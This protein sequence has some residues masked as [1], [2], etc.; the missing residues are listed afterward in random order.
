MSFETACRR[1]TPNEIR[2]ELT[3][4]LAS[5]EFLAS[6]HLTQFLRYVV[7]E[8]LAGR[9][10]LIKERS[11][12]L[13]ALDRDN[14]FDPREDCIVRV[15]AGKL[16]RAL[17]RYYA[18]EGAESSVR[19]SV[20]KGA[21]RPVFC[22]PA[23]RG[24]VRRRTG[25]GPAGLQVAS[26]SADRQ[27]I[28]RPV[29]AVVPLVPFT[30]GE[31]ER[32]LADSLAQDVAVHLSKVGWI[33]VIDYLATRSDAA[34]G[35]GPLEVASRLHA[36]YALTGTVRR[37]ESAARVTSQLLSVPDGSTVW[38]DQFDLTF[39]LPEL[40]GHDDVVL[41]ILQTIVE[42]FGV[43]GQAPWSRA[44][45]KPIE[46][47]SASAAEL[48]TF[49][50]QTQMEDLA[51]PEVVKAAERGTCA[52]PDFASGWAAQADL[53]STEFGDSAQGSDSDA[54]QRAGHR[55]E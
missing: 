42:I 5:A 1:P 23:K 43:V 24:A 20:P 15:V 30:G 16:R 14:D 39:D 18:N 29:L 12:A 53:G 37:K 10:D 27:G 7:T 44:G 9:E 50:Y 41:R 3:R 4:I 8:T 6:G 35:C 2:T 49:N 34:S 38:A 25:S 22:G 55:V 40:N 21:Y 47:L 52:S 46:K 48:P 31:P 19:L 51:F 36:D 11:I 13:N 17:E 26:G 54:E 32:L 28:N 33:E 45:G